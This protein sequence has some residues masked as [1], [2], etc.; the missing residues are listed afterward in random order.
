M[1]TLAVA[2]PMSGPRPFARSIDPKRWLRE[3]FARQPLLT[4]F[5]V[6]DGGV[7]MELTTPTGAA[8]VAAETTAGVKAVRDHLIL[9]DNWSGFYVAPVVS[10]SHRRRSSG[11]LMW[12]AVGVVAGL[13][14]VGLLV[15]VKVLRA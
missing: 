4:G 15:L 13:A 10:G 9:I 12:L 6:E 7:A 2:R 1:K 8:I 11:T 14:V 3:A 5:A